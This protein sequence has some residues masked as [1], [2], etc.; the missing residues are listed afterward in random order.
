MFFSIN[1]D[2]YIGYIHTLTTDCAWLNACQLLMKAQ[3]QV[4]RLVQ[5][6]ALTYMRAA[7]QKLSEGI[8][9]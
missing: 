3:G 7:L 2:T 4:S 8:R 9:S 6:Y 1:E 5:I